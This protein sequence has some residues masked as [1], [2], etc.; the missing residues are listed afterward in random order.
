M[1]TRIVDA[2]VAASGAIQRSAYKGARWRSPIVDL[3]C[4]YAWIGAS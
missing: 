4:R 1:S 3:S 2:A